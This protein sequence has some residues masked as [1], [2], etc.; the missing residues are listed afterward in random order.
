MLLPPLMDGTSIWNQIKQG[1]NKPN[2]GVI[3]PIHSLCLPRSMH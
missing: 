3:F 2:K 1:H